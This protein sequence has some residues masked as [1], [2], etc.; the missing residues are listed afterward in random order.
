MRE[1]SDGNYDGET[2]AVSGGNGT[3]ELGNEFI[4]SMMMMMMTRMIS[5]G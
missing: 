5:L 4:T 1:Y 2:V 3:V